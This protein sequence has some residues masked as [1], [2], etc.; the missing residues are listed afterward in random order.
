MKTT[1]RRPDTTIEFLEARIA[2]ATFR[3]NSPG[4]GDWNNQ[5]NWFNETTGMAANGFPNAIDDVAKFTNANTA[6]A[7]VNINGVN[8]TAGAILFD[9]SA[10]YQISALGGGTLT[11]SSAGTATIT[12]TKNFGDSAHLITAPVILASP[13]SIDQ[14]VSS[15]FTIN[16]VISEATPGK[17]FT[18]LGDG[19]VSLLGNTSNT[20]TGLTTI[21]AGTLS[22]Q[23]VTN[24]NGVGGNVVV[25][26]FSRDATL[27]I[28]NSSQLPDTAALTVNA[29]GTAAVNFSEI[30][31]ALT[32]NDG[33]CNLGSLT[34]NFLTV[35]SLNMTG[36]QIQ[37]NVANQVFNVSGDATATSDATGSAMISGGNVSLGLATRT[38]FVNDGPQAQDLTIN[39]AITGGA[40]VGLMKSGAGVL[41]FGGSATNTYT[42]TTTVLAG[43]LELAKPSGNS[44]SG[45]LVIGDSSGGVEADV[46]R[47][48]NGNQIAN[49][50]LVTVTSSGLL[51]VNGQLEFVGSLSVLGGHAT[52]GST[53]TTFTIQ[54]G[55][56]L[57]G[58]RLT[59]GAAGSVVA[60][61][62]SVTISN[63]A[64]S[65]LD[66]T[67]TFSLGAGTTNLSVLDGPADVDLLVT[68]P[69]TGA[70]KLSKTGLGTLE[71]DAANTYTGG[72]LVFGRL[73]VNGSV[74]DVA[75]G[76]SQAALAGTGTI[77]NLSLNAGAIKPGNSPGILHTG[78]ISGGNGDTFYFE[79]D[80][81]HPGN[82]AGFHDQIAVTGT[83]DLTNT[84]ANFTISTG[85]AAGDQYELIDNDGSDPV[86][87]T[88]NGLPEGAVMTIGSHR[89]ILTYKGGTGNDV[90]LTPEQ[91]YII[92]GDLVPGA[93]DAFIV[94]RD[95][96]DPDLVHI[97][98]YVAYVAPVTYDVS[99][100]QFANIVI[101]GGEGNDG[102]TFSATNGFIT[103]AFPN[104]IDA[105]KFDG[106]VGANYAGLSGN[107]ATPI[108]A[109]YLG[110]Y[111]GPQY[112]Q[113]SVSGGFRMSFD[114]V[115]Y[116]QDDL[117]ATDFYVSGNT[118]QAETLYVNAYGFF[119][120]TTGIAG[121]VPALVS[122]KTNVHLAGNGGGDTYE[123]GNLTVANQPT[124][125]QIQAATDQ[126]EALE[127]TGGVGD[128]TFTVT[129][130]SPTEGA[131]THTGQPM[132]SYSGAV[133]LSLDGDAGADTFNLP[134]TNLNARITGGPGA[135][136]LSF[137][138]GTA[139][140]ALH[141]DQ[142][143]Q[144]QTL[145][146]GA[147]LVLG[148]TV[149]TVVG[150]D[151]ADSF[152]AKTSLLGRTLNGGAG[153]DTLVFDAQGADAAKSAGTITTPGFG[154]LATTGV[155][156]ITLLNVPA[157]PALG[158]PSNTFATPFDFSSGKGAVSV[159]V[160]DL[161]GDGLADFVTAD[162][163]GGTV[164]IAL[165]TG[166]G[167][168]LPAVQKLSGGKKPASVVLG[169]FDGV[170]GLD[171]AV[172]NNASGT[173][174]ILLNDGSGDFANATTVKTGKTPGLLRVGNL[175]GDT[176]LDLAMITAGNKISV[177]KN[178]GTGAF[179]ASPAIP[180]GATV[181][182][183]LRL[184][185]LDGDGD[186]DLAVLHAGGQLAVQLNDGAANF[187][188]QTLGRLGAGATALAIADFNNDGK[189]DV[190]ATHASVSRF[191]AVA[192]GQG[193]GAFLP[194]L[195]VAY[196]L[197]GKASALLASDFD[198]DGITDLA[199]ANGAGGR[200]SILRGLGSGAFTKAL[201]LELE[202]TP[203]RKLAAL[204]LGDFN[205]D[206]RADLV[207]LSGASGDVSVILRA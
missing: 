101:Q 193:T 201:T 140:I 176:D 139:G 60:L 107:V 110:N 30:I 46:V 42:G 129:T 51:D 69:I 127:I 187:T 188:P 77:G 56:T 4:G 194:M 14:E 44:I 26:G 163:K 98:D 21:Q 33:V 135:D 1:L 74:G 16:A 196:P 37:M 106:G 78:S 113:V 112:G 13:L 205:G 162:S 84:N 186:L 202:D 124:T 180:T 23:K 157:K 88:F 24:M 79:I 191:V 9:D 87:G 93:D 91:S 126:T 149:E 22:L 195:K 141:L 10:I 154:A 175:D 68:A 89:Y 204:A 159:A 6:G 92:K 122:H 50:V 85:Y 115:Q 36:G 184:A 153:N 27:A 146:A 102:V 75:I 43:T 150:T 185:D 148:D 62:A 155:E 173:V 96:N 81:A 152:Y 134:T 119:G 32:I 41:R 53:A 168:L 11:L 143:G 49:N 71:L 125:I 73:I 100:H 104:V 130:T 35:S 3:W 136:T 207:A 38:F 158:A 54:S 147:Q 121:H 170:N 128:E 48:I 142:P 116:Y 179:T 2:P 131:I 137:A 161:N 120:I 105:I 47:L 61:P 108:D 181:P 64:Q 67:G 94:T 20:F 55:L 5:A 7:I 178:D 52:T 177:L 174:G 166:N 40:G 160:G 151:Q 18:K 76:S 83:V 117:P 82:G 145:N 28:A 17:T 15:N 118:G 200:V 171:I 133:R 59:A 70:G 199:V 138:A 63:G 90:V 164:S 206:G 183:D 19:K 123:I 8:V 109:V 182:K 167:L 169:D 39:S 57:Q 31:G 86:T 65:L 34:L 144:T 72:T 203:A 58:G 198:G 12:V 189:L 192:L 197:P 66:G 95:A 99:L 45:P 190:A 103:S 29:Q 172:T 114:Q 111:G 80:G 132:V 25:G 97:T 165:S 156:T